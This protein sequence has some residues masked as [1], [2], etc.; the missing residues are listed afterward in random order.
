MD[1]SVYLR[2]ERCVC[3]DYNQSHSEQVICENVHS[4]ENAAV[5]WQFYRANQINEAL[6][7]EMNPMAIRFVKAFLDVLTERVWEVG[8]LDNFQ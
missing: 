8:M 2:K 6:R 5:E 4:C 7:P 1:W 3:L